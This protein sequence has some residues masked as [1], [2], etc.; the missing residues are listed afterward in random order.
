MILGDGNRLLYTEDSLS[1]P[2]SDCTNAGSR[3]RKGQGGFKVGLIPGVEPIRPA[4][5]RRIA[6]DYRGPKR[7]VDAACDHN[8]VVT[9]RC[10]PDLV[11]GLEWL[12]ERSAG[13]P[14]RPE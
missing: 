6:N 7:V 1:E 3:S 14:E 13:S 5:Q 12:L 9:A 2:T 8:D 4:D 10:A 11:A